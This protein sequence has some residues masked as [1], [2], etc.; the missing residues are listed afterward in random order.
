MRE[1]EGNAMARTKLKGKGLRKAIEKLS[2]DRDK[3]EGE[4]QGKGLQEE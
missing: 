4:R 2:Q 3:A 1:A